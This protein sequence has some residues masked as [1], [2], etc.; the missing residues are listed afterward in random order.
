MTVW[1]TRVEISHIQSVVGMLSVLVAK[2]IPELSKESMLVPDL[3]SLLL[4]GVAPD[5][6]G[7]II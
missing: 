4:V 6:G 1:S 2:S 3:V 5:V 7:Y